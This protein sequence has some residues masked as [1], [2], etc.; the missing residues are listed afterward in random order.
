MRIIFY[1]FIFI[2]VLP[3]SLAAQVEGLN[4]LYSDFLAAKRN[5]PEYWTTVRGSAYENPEFKNAYV[6]LRNKP[7]PDMTM[8]RYNILF[9][10]M[11]MQSSTKDQFLFINNK[12]AIERIEMDDKIFRYTHF[13]EGKDLNQGFLIELVT[14]KYSLYTRKNRE[15]QEEKPPTGG[16]QDYIPPSII[17]KSD[18]YFVRFNDNDTPLLLPQSSKNIIKI[19][20]SRGIDISAYAKS[21]RIKYDENSLIPLIEFCNSQK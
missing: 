15:F 21:N 4:N 16:Y 9:D 5:D 6:Y 14:G 18:T 17:N 20:Q 19:F 12:S 10:E 13:Q 11:E 7:T 2:S 1:I 8:I 3:F